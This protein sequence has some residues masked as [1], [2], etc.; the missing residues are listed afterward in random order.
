MTDLQIGLLVIGAAAV[1][2]VVIYNRVQERATRREAQRAFGSR[3]ADALLDE[4]APRR[5]PS[6]DSFHARATVSPSAALPDDKVDYVLQLKGLSTAAT[7]SEW[8]SL[9]RR[10]APRAFLAEAHDGVRA[11][12]QMVSRK[13][14]VSEA[15]LLEFRSQVET[16]AAAHG[17]SASAPEMRAALEGAHELDRAC[18]D[19]DVQI[20][21]HVLGVSSGAMEGMP[22]Q[23]KERDDGVTLLLDVPRTPDLARS[24]E[25]MVRAARDLG[26]RLV[27]DNG[28]TLDERALAAI[29]VEVDALHA[30][31][32]ELG[33][34]PGSPLAL[35]LFS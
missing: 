26:G 8:Q 29:G 16:L 28:N 31:L 22:F 32:A 10:F 5:E 34:Q 19:V 18:A 20:A 21:L 7:A 15:E 23:V 11:A 25:E 30:R 35:R 17:A 3:H 2:G 24:Y 6:A 9:E 4:P 14:V 12:L 1:A 27:D 13:G 33:I